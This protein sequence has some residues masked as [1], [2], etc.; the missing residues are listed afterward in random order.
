ML[1]DSSI[2]FHTMVTDDDQI[3]VWID[4]WKCRNEHWRKPPG[5]RPPVWEVDFST[6]G[7]AIIEAIKHV[8]KS[9]P[10]SN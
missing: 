6:L 10:P 1:V 8:T 3:M 4:C 2:D 7:Q 5:E 9:H